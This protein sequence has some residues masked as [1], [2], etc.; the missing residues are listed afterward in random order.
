M[1][2]LLN[3]LLLGSTT[4][5]SV[6]TAGGN[7]TYEQKKAEMEL[8]AQKLLQLQLLQYQQSNAMLV[9]NITTLN[10]L[11]QQQILQSG[12]T[13]SDLVSP[14]NSILTG[15]VLFSF[16]DKLLLDRVI[17][18]SKSFVTHKTFLL[19]VCEKTGIKMIFF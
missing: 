4:V 2:N 16:L 7:N 18:H 13:P 17:L 6:D 12:S 15:F 10:L 1:D 11:S 3:Y 9:Q 8:N 5:L 14:N 19:F